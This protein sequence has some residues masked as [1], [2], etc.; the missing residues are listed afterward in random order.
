[1]LLPIGK[2][3]EHKWKEVETS[4]KPPEGRYHHGM[5]YYD[6]G[7]YIVLFGGRRFS[8]PEEG[9]ISEF[10]EQ[11]CLLKMDTLEWHEVYFR[12]KG[13]PELYNFASNIINDQMLVFGGMKKDYSYSN[14][15]YSISLETKKTVCRRPR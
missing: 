2:D 6:R 10:V 1:M 12:N 3:V 11:I 8:D 15:L 4:G 14:N 9:H 5:H 13:F 7:N